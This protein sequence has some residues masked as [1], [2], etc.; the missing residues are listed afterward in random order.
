VG[1]LVLRAQV[2]GIVLAGYLADEHALASSPPIWLQFV[3]QMPVTVASQ[4]RVMHVSVIVRPPAW[5]D[6]CHRALQK[7]RQ[8]RQEGVHSLLPPGKRRVGLAERIVSLLQKLLQA[9][10][11]RCEGVQDARPHRPP[12][13]ARCIHGDPGPGYACGNALPVLSGAA[14]SNTRQ[15]GPARIGATRSKCP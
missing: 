9:S 8:F 4:A 1:V 3:C 10:L 6:E 11:M 2:S 13:R 12:G 14:D 5:R 7:L 15:A